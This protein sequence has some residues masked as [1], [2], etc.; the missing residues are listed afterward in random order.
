MPTT[1]TSTGYWISA[2]GAAVL[3]I[4]LTVLANAL[5]PRTRFDRSATEIA[6]AAAAFWGALAAVLVATMWGSYYTFFAPEWQRPLAPLSSILY[7]GIGLI[8]WWLARRTPLPPA[9]AFLL[10]GG[11]ESLAEHAAA[12]WGAGLFKKV[13]MLT[14]VDPAAVLVFAFFEYVIYWGL[15]L[16]LA[17][18]LAGSL[19]ALRNCIRRRAPS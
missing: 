8:L 16:V 4:P 17:R 18:L 9:I 13:P 10:L 11:M 5:L 12:I 1:L 2:A 7:A 3:A 15:T 19:T 14:G 6:L